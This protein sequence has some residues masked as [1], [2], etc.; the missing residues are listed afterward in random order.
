MKRFMMGFGAGSI[1]SPV[2][3]AIAVVIWA[4]IYSTTHETELDAPVLPNTQAEYD[5]NLYTPGGD[6][7][8]LSSMKGKVVFLTVWKPTCGVCVAEL[9]HI[10]ALYDEFAEEEGVAFAAIATEGGDPLL[11]LIMEYDLTMPI[12]TYKGD[13]PEMYSINTVPF[14]FVLAPDGTVAM[15][16]K[17]AARWDDDATIA[18][19]RGLLREEGN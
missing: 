7:V 10:Q 19:I 12:Y 2:L 5:W 3:I 13:R 1:T 14:T 17:G 8:P 6:S 18:F 11:D 4:R 9:P 16:Y 15:R